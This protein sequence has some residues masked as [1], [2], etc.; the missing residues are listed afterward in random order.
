MVYSLAWGETKG[1]ET[2]EVP[3]P[4]FLV[5]ELAALIEGKGSDDLVFTAP[6]GGVMR[7]QQIQRQALNAAA[8]A[9]GL[10]T[11]TETDEVDE[12]GNPVVVWSG[13]LHPHELRHTAASLAIAS[14]ADV[15]VV[16]TMLGHKSATL[17]LDLYGHLFGDRLDVVS[18]AMDAARTV[19]LQNRVSNPC[20]TGQVIPMKSRADS[21]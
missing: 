1:H 18:D 11:A 15:K 8:E 16:Q 10:A 12:D 6:H 9:M 2:R 14:G 7:A 20:P 17:T 3:I 5:A 19:A 13:H 21:A 4:P